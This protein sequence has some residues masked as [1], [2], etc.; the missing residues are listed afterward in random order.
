MKTK[1]FR[2]YRLSEEADRIIC[3]RL[4][5]EVAKTGKAQNKTGTLET[6]LKEELKRLK[7]YK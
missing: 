5:R 2:V 4:V 3:Q 7:K 1:P 6:I